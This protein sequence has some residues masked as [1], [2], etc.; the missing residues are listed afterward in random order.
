MKTRGMQMKM[1]KRRENGLF[2]DKSDRTH[3]RK[4]AKRCRWQSKRA[5]FEEAAGELRAK[6]S[7]ATNAATV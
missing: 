6:A 7:K 1:G 3:M 5:D 2:S 4:S